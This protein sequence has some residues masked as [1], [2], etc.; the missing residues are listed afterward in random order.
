MANISK[1]KF[2]FQLFFITIFIL[3][4]K[5]CM[6]PINDDASDLKNSFDIIDNIMDP[7]GENLNL[8]FEQGLDFWRFNS[9]KLFFA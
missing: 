5:S 9:K 3:L 6:E 8:D 7:N 2:L 4:F 1:V